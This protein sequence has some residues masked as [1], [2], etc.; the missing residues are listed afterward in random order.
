[1]HY[2]HV[3]DVL[4][5]DPSDPAGSFCGQLTNV[6][7]HGEIDRYFSIKNHGPNEPAPYFADRFRSTLV[8]TNPQTGLTYT[9]VRVRQS[10]DL[11]IVDDGDGTLTLTGLNTRSLWA[12]GPDGQL[13]GRQNGLTRETFLVDTVGT[14]D[15]N[16]DVLVPQGDAFTAGLDHRKLLQRLRECYLRVRNHWTSVVSML[17]IPE[18]STTCGTAT[19]PQFRAGAQLRESRRRS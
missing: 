5:P 18:V 14:H 17:Q 15:P 2:S 16:D 4:L 9:V 8:H 3:Y 19:S 7:L 13:L 1:M 12:Y 6:P 11:S 10:K